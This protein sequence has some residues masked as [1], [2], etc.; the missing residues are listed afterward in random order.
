MGF[1]LVEHIEYNLL[2]RPTHNVVILAAL[3]EVDLRPI[4]NF[5]P[6]H[7]LKCLA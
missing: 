5:T 6:H 3:D 1:V 7:L 4:K 2:L